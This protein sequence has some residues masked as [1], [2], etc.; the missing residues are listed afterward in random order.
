MWIF[1]NGIFKLNYFCQL[2]RYLKNFYKILPTFS[3]FERFLMSVFEMGRLDGL[4]NFE[5]FLLRFLGV[6][7]K[8]KI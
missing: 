1:S 8:P 5:T 6:H 3:I 2:I 4:I 7:F